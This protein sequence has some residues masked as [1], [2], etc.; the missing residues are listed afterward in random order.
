[1]SDD[2][3]AYLI[4]VTPESYVFENDDIDRGVNSNSKIQ[5]H[6]ML[7]GTCKIGVTSAYAR[8]KGKYRLRYKLD[9]ITFPAQ[10]QEL[11]RGMIRSKLDAG[12]ARLA[13][14]RLLSWYKFEITE[15]VD[16]FLHVSS[17]SFDTFVFVVSP[18]GMRFENDDY[19]RNVNENSRLEVTLSE[20][21]SYYVGV[22]SCTVGESGL[23]LLI[24]DIN[25]KKRGII[26]T[27][28]EI[29]EI[30]PGKIDGILSIRDYFYENR[31]AHFFE[32]EVNSGDY[33]DLT[34]TSDDF[35]TLMVLK[36][37]SEKEI[38]SETFST[39]WHITR[40]QLRLLEKGRYFLV[41]TSDAEG[42]IGKYE[43]LFN[44]K[45][46]SKPYET[47]ELG[48]NKNT[49]T[50]KD[51]KYLGKY[52]K[53]YQFKVSKGDLITIRCNSA[54][55]DTLLLLVTPDN[56]H[57]EN[58]DVDSGSRN[59]R[60]S[61]MINVSG[62]CVL[63]V[64]SYRYEN[65]GNFILKY[66]KGVLE[67]PVLEVGKHEGE[68]DTS[69]LLSGYGRLADYYVF[70]GKAGYSVQ[71]QMQSKE[72]D[73]YIKVI[74]PSALE[75][76]NDDA[77]LEKTG[78]SELTF[79]LSEDGKY[80]IVASTSKN[81]QKGKYSLIFKMT[82]YEIGEISE[83]LTEGV[84]EKDSILLKT[85]SYV[86]WY[87]LS[88]MKNRWAKLT[89]KS[90]DFDT[91]L[92]MITPDGERIENNNASPGTFDSEIRHKFSEGIYMVGVTSFNR[93]EVGQY[94]TQL[95]LESV[96]TNQSASI[97]LKVGEKIEKG[98]LNSGDRRS[99]DG[100]LFD[101][102]ILGVKKGS[103][104]QI[105]LESKD[106]DTQI[107]VYSP[108]KRRIRNDDIAQGNKNSRLILKCDFEGDLQILVLPNLIRE[109]GVYT[110]STELLEKI[111]EK[112]NYVT[113]SG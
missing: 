98:E 25:V 16:I 73:S 18:T 30:K 56:I 97:R 37:P 57:Y 91:Y 49:L 112:F 24:F 53:W 82:G 72:I 108:D 40:I 43:L 76:E 113:L 79:T 67:F 94:Y 107:L 41:V 99:D 3:D 34:L 63:G 69:D 1:M 38:L 44:L 104:L 83:K 60:I 8:H 12:S 70:Y 39:S 11:S 27:E 64:S 111:P 7:N 61:V 93:G 109:Q 55:F 80:K 33:V 66:S 51:E 15:P 85:G 46:A 77:S 47:L 89:L 36:S 45:P 2:F 42:N 50:T 92:I 106:F 9:K 59:S 68:L 28:P 87:T 81:Q 35:D 4:L 96:N 58:D 17:V 48:D 102:Y 71:I 31:R 52:I 32:F 88:G 75:C 95:V 110:F 14:E 10:C 105:N 103:I 21:G 100:R 54:Q 20:T 65:I 19:K 90:P 101:E 62:D 5:R 23:F 78:D 26:V 22:T 86:N 13:N 6:I 29:T 74:Y 84:L